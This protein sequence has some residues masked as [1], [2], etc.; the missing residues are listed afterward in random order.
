MRRYPPA[1][2]LMVAVLVAAVVLPSS[3][4]LPQSNPSTV[5][6]YA[7]VPPDEQT[8]LESSGQ[9]GFASLGVASSSSLTLAPRTPPTLDALSKRPLTKRCVGGRQTEDPNSPPCQPYFEGDN[10]GI[11]WQ[12]VTRDEIVIVIYQTA[13]LATIGGAQG[14][15]TPPPGGPYCDIELLDCNGDGRPDDNV[16]EFVRIHNA[17]SRYF[18]ARFQTYGRH[19]KP[20]MFWSAATSASARRSDA[21]DIW[22]RLKPFAVMPEAGAGG[23][24]EEFIDAMAQRNVMVFSTLVGYPASYYSK[25]APKVWSFWPSIEI[26]AQ[27]YGNYLC[28]KVKGTVVNHSGAE[29]QGK[30]R[31]YGL[32]YTHDASRPG[33][34]QFA[35]TVK[36]AIGPAGCGMIDANTPEATFPWHGYGVDGY[37]PFTYPQTNMSYMRGKEANTLLWLAG[38][39]TQQ[40]KAAANQN[41]FPEIIVAGEGLNESNDS[42]QFQDQSVWNNAWVQTWQLRSGRQQ[43][44]PGYVAYK[45]AEPDGEDY[46][47]AIANSDYRFWLLT[48]TAIQVA[49]P[50]LAPK[51]VDAG[52]H[53]IQRK[54]STSPFVPSFYFFPNDYTGVKDATEMWY[55][56]SSQ[57]PEGDQGCWRLVREGL[58]Y[59]PDAW[60]SARGRG[61]DRPN[62][63]GTPEGQSDPCT[64][65]TTPVTVRQPRS[66]GS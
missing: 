4:N 10:F 26:W 56:A 20:W 34:R 63:R 19:I 2:I 65:Y 15:E 14:A 16:H 45:E 59:P 23:F 5:L 49:G 29:F 28:T 66:P 40:S 64:G 42:G 52:M 32:I 3:L 30:P 51:A 33:L 27:M 9:G 13:Y 24:N 36:S 58:R 35:Q 1:S 21:A 22:A 48:M 11:T 8:A 6:E 54:V 53:A 47:W 57:D 37:E 62:Y 38:Y 44:D 46:G 55:D 7:P 41:Y 39:E 18:N 43:E 50:R 25:Y 17:Y 61:I 12:G 31:K 60:A